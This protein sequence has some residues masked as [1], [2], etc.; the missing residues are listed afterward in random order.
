MVQN[1]S[2]CF[3]PLITYL[4]LQKGMSPIAVHASNFTEESTVT[5]IRLHTVLYVCNQRWP[6]HTF[7]RAYVYTYTLL[8]LAESPLAYDWKCAGRFCDTATTAATCGKLRALSCRDAPGTWQCS[9][10]GNRIA[11]CPGPAAKSDRGERRCFAPGTSYRP[12]PRSPHA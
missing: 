6:L 2:V 12:A 8:L 9:R 4:R 11:L 7:L 5:Y 1:N 3:G 10:A